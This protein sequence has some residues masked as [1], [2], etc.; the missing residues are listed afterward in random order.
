M[1][2]QEAHLDVLWSYWYDLNINKFIQMLFTKMLNVNAYLHGLIGSI[3][4][5]KGRKSSM[6]KKI[7]KAKSQG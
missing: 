4:F 6:K 2:I 1:L 7:W 5:V 3:G